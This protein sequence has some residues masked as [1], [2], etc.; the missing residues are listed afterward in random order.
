ML[1]YLCIVL[2]VLGVR[3][4]TLQDNR[5][6]AR[7]VGDITICS[8]IL[9]AWIVFAVWLHRWSA[10]PPSPRMRIRAWRQELTAL[11]NGFEPQSGGGAA[12]ASLITAEDRIH[13][14]ARFVADGIEFGNIRYRS[15]SRSGSWQYIALHLH[16]PLPHMLLESQAGKSLARMLP[17]HISGYQ[18]LSL[19]GDFDRWFRL[20][21]PAGYERDALFL[22][23]PDVMAALI[24]HAPAF[25]MET[26]AD[27]M[28]FFRSSAADF[29]NP[30]PWKVVAEVIEG[31][32]KPFVRNASGYRDERIPEQDTPYA[33]EMMPTGRI[34]SDGTRLDLR[35]RRTGI[36]WILG[37]TGWA[38]TLV[39]LYAVPAIFAFAGLMSIV[40]G[41]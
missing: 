40:D 28:V 30:E 3:I 32:A 20:F 12:F 16:A 36:W 6:E 35:D 18:T 39:F 19:E 21:V 29:A 10:R 38:A 33:V 1:W 31:A 5:I 23:P 2:M 15:R 27:R 34:A 13:S 9:V 17:V 37:A 14:S 26:I 4:D 25:S 22:L 7:D 41:R 24:D 8:A 11:S